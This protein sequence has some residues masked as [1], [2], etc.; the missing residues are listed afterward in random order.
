M[1]NIFSEEELQENFPSLS[2]NQR[3]ALFNS[4]ISLV[5]SYLGCN[6]ELKVTKKVEIKPLS[7]NDLILSRY[8]LVL[9]EQEPI[10]IEIKNFNQSVWLKVNVEN[11]SINLEQ[12]I[13]NF[14][15]PI[16]DGFN[17][18]YTGN[19]NRVL[20]RQGRNNRV[21]IKV[22][23][24]SGWKFDSLVLLTEEEKQIKNNL[25]ALMQLKASSQYQ[26]SIKRFKLDGHYEVEYHSDNINNSTNLSGRDNSKISEILS[27]F[28]K[29]SPRTQVF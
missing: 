21:L 26:E 7:D 18:Y 16:Y 3:E 20:N 27:W 5:E 6:R 14:K 23:Y 28:K 19:S 2:L 17:R 10:E 4:S 29:L 8:P 1:S 22:N 25:M 24:Y 12:G 15:V 9:S 11:A 13:I